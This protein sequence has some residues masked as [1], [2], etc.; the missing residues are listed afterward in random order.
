MRISDRSEER[1]LAAHQ[2]ITQHCHALFF[3]SPLYAHQRARSW[4]E[5]ERLLN[6]PEAPE[7]PNSE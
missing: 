3:D 5:L 7:A 1:K 6:E 2:E 4:T